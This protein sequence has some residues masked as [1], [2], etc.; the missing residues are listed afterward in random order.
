MIRHFVILGL[1]VL[2][3]C[4]LFNPSSRPLLKS[5]TLEQKCHSI[6]EFKEEAALL[7]PSEDQAILIQWER[8]GVLSSVFRTTDTRCSDK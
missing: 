5:K 2:S 6:G 7:F 1:T 3:G 8:I 4:A